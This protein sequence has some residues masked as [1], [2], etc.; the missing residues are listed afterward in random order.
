MRG[1][2]L[3]TCV[4]SDWYAKKE[5]VLARVQALPSDAPL[6]I[7]VAAWGEIEFGF[8]TAPPAKLDYLEGFKRFVARIAITRD[9]TKHTVPCY[10][11]LRALLFE[12][13]APKAKRKKNLRPEQLV[14]PVTS[15]ELV[16]QENDLWM[17]AQAMEFNFVL[18]TCDRMSRIADVASGLLAIEN[19][20]A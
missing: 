19:W 2:F 18:A 3:D 20:L 11:Q 6:W 4:I 13:F 10:G 1:Y 7:S 9:I 14:D 12:N 15:L 8:R 16:I 5:G 17:A